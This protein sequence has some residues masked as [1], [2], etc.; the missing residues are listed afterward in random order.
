MKIFQTG[1][2]KVQKL[3]L[4]MQAI[5][6]V[7][8]EG[9]LIATSYNAKTKCSKDLRFYPLK[10][11]FVVTAQMNGVFFEREHKNAERAVDDYNETYT[12]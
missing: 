9:V 7:L 10:N 8:K 11:T 6:D 3:K 2:K 4:T 12:D 1:R 5:E